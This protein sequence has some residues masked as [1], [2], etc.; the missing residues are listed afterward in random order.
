M[1]WVT[2]SSDLLVAT[3]HPAVI[4]LV[5]HYTTSVMICHLFCGKSVLL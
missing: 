4:V 1:L 2:K 5:S 3:A